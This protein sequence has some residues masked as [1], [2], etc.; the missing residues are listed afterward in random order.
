MARE[1]RV[2]RMATVVRRV[3]VVR[4]KFDQGGQVYVEAAWPS[5]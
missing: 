1:T 3:R 2:A 4:V 5:G